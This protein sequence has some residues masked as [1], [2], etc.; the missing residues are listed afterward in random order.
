[1][2]QPKLWS[3]NKGDSAYWKDFNWDA[4]IVAGM[5]YLKLP[6]SG[7]YDFGETEMYWPLNHQVSPASK[8][9]QCIDCHTNNEEG[10]LASLT[11]FYLPGRDR[12]AAIDTFGLFLLAMTLLGTIIHGGIRLFTRRNRIH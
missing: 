7:E 9:L 10:R 4:S 2:V 5:N 12:F 11:D 3:P 8:S 6:Y 1:L